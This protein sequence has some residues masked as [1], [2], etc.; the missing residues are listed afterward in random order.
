MA[1]YADTSV[2][3][4]VDRRASHTVSMSSSFSATSLAKALPV[5]V[6]HPAIGDDEGEDA[7]VD[8]GLE[9]DLEEADVD[10]GPADHRLA[11]AAIGVATSGG[12]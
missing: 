11:V 8:E 6:L 5:L 4:G 1:G 3:E 10:V 12:D 9:G 2:L 7:T